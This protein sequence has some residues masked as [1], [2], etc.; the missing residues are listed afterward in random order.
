MPVNYL[1]RHFFV[2]GM[3][4]CFFI[5]SRSEIKTISLAYNLGEFVLTKDSDNRVTITSVL[6]NLAL[7]SD[8]TKA[9]VPYVSVNVLM[10]MEAKFKGISVESQSIRI[11]DDVSL[12]PLPVGVVG[13][14]EEIP[15]VA[16][17]GDNTNMTSSADI[18]QFTGRDSYRGYNI[19]HFLV[20][21][22]NYIERCISLN[23]E[24][25]F[26]IEYS[27]QGKPDV[28]LSKREV[29]LNWLVI[30]P[31]DVETY[32][33]LAKMR[34]HSATTNGDLLQYAI[35]TKREFAD[36][37]KPLV[38]WKNI[39]GVR[40]EMFFVEDVYSQFPDEKTDQ[41]KIKRFIEKLYTDR[42]VIYV[43]LGGDA[44]VIPAQEVYAE[45]YMSLMFLYYKGFIRSDLFYASL[46]GSFNWDGNDNGIIGDLDD[47]IHFMPSVNISRI[48]AATAVEVNNI[49]D[50]IINYERFSIAKNWKNDLVLADH[51]MFKDDFSGTY[52]NSIELKSDLICEKY[53]SPY[54]EGKIFKL[55]D[56]HCDCNEKWGGFY[57]EHILSELSR[58]HSFFNFFTHGFQLYIETVYDE[59]FGNTVAGINNPSPTIVTSGACHICDFTEAGNESFGSEVL[60]SATDNII[61]LYGCT[62][63][64]MY[65]ISKNEPKI[66][67]MPSY[68]GNFY[69]RMFLSRNSE[70]HLGLIYSMSKSEFIPNCNDKNWWRWD[71]LS[72][73]MFGDPEMPVYTNIPKEFGA[74]QIKIT[75]MGDKYEVSLNPTVQDYSVGVTKFE[76]GNYKIRESF[77]QSG[78]ESATFTTDE[79]TINICITKDGY[80]PYVIVFNPK[81][82]YL[83]NETFSD[84]AVFISPTIKM[85]TNVTQS[86]EPGNVVFKGDS[87]G[88]YL[89]RGKN[90]NI[91]AGTIF[92]PGAQVEMDYTSF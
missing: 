24:I 82:L 49:V 5:S 33:E 72:I 6:H 10:P 57:P 28:A 84:G 43:L 23:K 90:I 92:Q 64:S 42:D 83:Q 19:F 65:E 25:E 67:G 34:N 73:N 52:P 22:F 39:K 47:G 31:E 91:G 14:P 12:P 11:M 54:W 71:M 50:K 87:R 48:P 40:T 16:H 46:S 1:K 66:G 89:L 8:S 53:I 15:S 61:A 2:I 85:G 18:V 70:N 80:S 29:N 26:A 79:E 60:L 32:Y 4:F 75:P 37:F 36:A 63:E 62:V 76:D 86:K 74:V 45:S 9:T 77:F 51:K 27:L 88:R 44:T 13:F 56:N 7:P 35:I 30:N 21:P 17:Q 59:L 20:R 38:D 78:S 68:I 81:C 58:G 3:I 55:H 41:L 69:K